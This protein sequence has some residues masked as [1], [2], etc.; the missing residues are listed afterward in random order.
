MCLGSCSH[1]SILCSHSF[2]DPFPMD[3]AVRTLRSTQERSAPAIL[4]LL[5]YPRL[6]KKKKK[7]KKRQQW[8]LNNVYFLGFCC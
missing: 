1:P 4:I 3:A 2:I 8:F 7:K 6:E 5:K